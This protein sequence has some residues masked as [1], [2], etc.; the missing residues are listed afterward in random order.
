M[1][2]NRPPST[3]KGHRLWFP[4]VVIV[5]AALGLVLIRQQSELERVIQLWLVGLILLLTAL[6]LLGWFLTLSRFPWRLKV[7]SLAV[8]ILAGFAL[9][10][11]LRID[12]TTDGTG[13]P[14]LAWTWSP[15][16]PTPAASPPMALVQTEL[17]N[18]APPRDL[19]DVPQFFGPNRDGILPTANFD[20]DWTTRP[21]KA[22]WRQPIG[23]GWSSFAVV[24]GRAYTQEQRGDSELVTCYEALTGRLLWAHTN[25]VRFRQWQ[26]GDGPRATP[27]VAANRVYACG[28][29]G[30][31]DCL[32][33]RTG[34]PLW[35]HPV[36]DEHRLPNLT[37][38]VSC[39]PLVFDD[40]VVVTGG[41]TNG[42]T[43]LAYHRLSGQPLWHA[44]TDK[45]GYAS[46]ILVNLGGQ[47]LVLSANARALT[48]HDPL[49]GNVR[50]EYPWPNEKPPKASQPVVLPGDRIFMSAGYGI[51]CL[52]LQVT[53][54]AN[55]NLVA[56]VLWKTRTLKTQFN[57]AAV[58]D[59]F[60]YGLDDGGLTCVDSRTGERKWKGGRFGSGQT[61]IVDNLILI[62][63]EP[64]D[65][66]LAQ[67]HPDAFRELARL[68]ALSH[69]TWNYPT[70][71]GRYLWVRNDREAAC[72]ELPS[73]SQ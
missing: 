1:N 10:R 35:Q 44:G 37:W 2:S 67:A 18:P 46:P 8:L 68:P 23:T 12:G 30:I 52:L 51:G 11:L 66:I 57:T 16:P 70:L 20:S 27:T 25:Q 43:L 31:L 72:F 39:S 54:T 40:T 36:L 45:A 59:G 28:A 73:K 9:T 6:L 49:N 19:T 34:A 22:L 38:G 24:D 55:N 15:S 26:G 21:P 71:A 14:K 58:R 50:F 69:K 3:L 47:R 5:V 61:L 60:L 17:P 7:G 56:T 63:S 4:A 62:Q 42:P 64:G 65:I 41:D 48:A 53:A 32:D 29:T 13:L 33:A